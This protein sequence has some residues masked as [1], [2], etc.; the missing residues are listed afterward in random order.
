MGEY[1]YSV[2]YECVCESGQCVC[3]TGELCC[4]Y[5]FGQDV[6]TDPLRQRFYCTFIYCNE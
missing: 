4:S 1:V 2:Q 6:Q 5:P 3:M